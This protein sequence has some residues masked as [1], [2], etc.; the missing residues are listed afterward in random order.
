MCIS[1]TPYFLEAIRLFVGCATRETIISKLLPVHYFIEN[2]L[3]SLL[4]LLFLALIFMISKEEK[5]GGT[6]ID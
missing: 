3:M 5:V 2:C 4:L 1:G 6:K